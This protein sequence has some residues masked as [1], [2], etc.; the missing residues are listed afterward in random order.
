MDDFLACARPASLHFVGV[1]A[2]ESPPSKASGS[3][4]SQAAV[5]AAFISSKRHQLR[6][7]DCPTEIVLCA[8]AIIAHSTTLIPTLT[9]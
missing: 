9:N 1:G 7:I 6:V 8:T 4:N 2:R 3:P 5:Q